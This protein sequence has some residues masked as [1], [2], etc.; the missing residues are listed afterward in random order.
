MLTKKFKFAVLSMIFL[1]A[2]LIP[3]N[4]YSQLTQQWAHRQNGSEYVE[5]NAT[6]MDAGG[7]VYVAC[8]GY[9][10]AS[11]YYILLMKFSASSA[12]SPLWIA[13]Y[14]GITGES[15]MAN[16]LVL[17]NSGNIYITGQIL[18]PNSMID[19]ITL[20][21]NNNGILQWSVRYNNSLNGYDRPTC[22]TVDPSGNVI[23]G[24]VTNSAP[25]QPYNYLII[26][27]SNA[28]VMQWVRTY[29]GPSTVDEDDVLSDITSDGSGNI[30]VTGKAGWTN[31][32]YDIV[33][34]KITPAGVLGA[35]R[36]DGAEHSDDFGKKIIVDAAG[37]YYV[38]GS[39]IESGVNP[40]ITIMKFSP[41]NVPLWTSFY[42]Y[43]SDMPTDM[44]MD[45]AGNLYITGY[46][47]DNSN[48]SFVTLKYNNNGSQL[49]S[50]RFIG[51]NIA[52]S[53]AIDGSGNV[54]VTGSSN[55]DIATIKYNQNGTLVGNAMIYNG[56]SSERGVTVIANSSGS[57]VFVTGLSFT[58]ENQDV[59]VIKYSQPVGISNT[60]SEIPRDFSLQQNYP[61][62]FNP[63]TMI[64]FSIPSENY[65]SI[66]VYDMLGKQVDEI[67]NENL[68][69]GNFE[70]KYDASKLSAGAY[71]YKIETSG[72]SETK[73]M[74]LIK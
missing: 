29:D 39:T 49:W 51:A 32:G 2:A 18:G 72:Y 10:S 22:L 48:Y 8:S 4:T 44:K 1:A 24:G 62:P 56:S 59:V 68:K 26:K 61:N 19:A 57:A 69:A 7:N 14:S 6:K 12:G 21:Y 17:D 38:T 41:G 35:T 55:N 3:E 20:K 64:K 54:Y 40:E 74:M 43:A 9:N 31:T 23:I 65:V 70:I 16:A 50:K 15:E 53:L 63:S 36:Y 30:Y 28:G 33:N 25:G 46:T 27:Y 71:F 73:K 67:V 5:T 52:N 34:L 11:G 13:A 45:N 42:D 60:N 66:K 58:V 47:N 37:N